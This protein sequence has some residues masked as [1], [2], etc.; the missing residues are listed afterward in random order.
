ML[1]W[2]IWFIYELKDFFISPPS[3]RDLERRGYIVNVERREKSAC[4][5]KQ[6]LIWASAKIVG[7]PGR[8]R[9]SKRAGHRR[10]RESKPRFNA[11][12]GTRHSVF[13]F[14]LYIAHISGVVHAAAAA[15]A[16]A[17][18][19][20]SVAAGAAPAAARSDLVGW[21]GEV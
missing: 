2:V 7:C 21:G 18:P 6:K 9:A 16:A 5:N 13:V 3:R 11:E 14:W 8:Y 1:I 20:L 10:G 12:P 19:R 17:V 15:N 4:S